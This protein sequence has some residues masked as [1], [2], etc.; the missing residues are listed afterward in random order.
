MRTNR[1][2]FRWVACQIDFLCECDSDLERE[3]ALDN[4]P[5]D[6]PKTYDRI[7]R[8]VNENR[9]KK[10]RTLVRNVLKWIVCAKEPLTLETVRHAVS[11]QANDT[12][13]FQEAIFDG[14]AIM[15]SCSSLIRLS[16]SDNTL[17]LA[18]FTV[19][20]YLLEIDE[21]T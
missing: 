11:I 6:L 12:K 8:R 13:L 9:N 15:K 2:R 18:H 16:E 7:L 10:R 19:K 4:L 3:Q 1:S 20:Q 5:P 14:Y 21:D 17:E